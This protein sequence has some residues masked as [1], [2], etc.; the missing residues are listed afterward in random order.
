MT[1]L[2]Y[3]PVPDKAYGWDLLYRLDPRSKL[4]FVI[5]LALY[6]ALAARPEVMLLT[7]AGLHLLSLFSAGT[8]ARLVPLW[9]ALLPLVK[10]ETARRFAFVCD[11]RHA[12]DLLEEGHLDAILRKAVTL[13]LDPLLAVQLATLNTAEIFGRRDVLQNES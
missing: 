1:E 5:G 2:L 10:P 11:D 6:L 7:L 9:Q 3:A 13:G 8:R 4:L 12:D